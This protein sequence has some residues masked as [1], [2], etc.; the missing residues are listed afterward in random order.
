MVGRYWL[1]EAR[2]PAAPALAN[3]WACATAGA[4]AGASASSP[5]SLS[6]SGAGSSGVGGS[7][8]TDSLAPTS[9]PSAAPAT[10]SVSR[11]AS[12]WRRAVDSASSAS[13][14]AARVAAPP[15]TPGGRGTKAGTFVFHRPGG[16]G[17]GGRPRGA[18]RGL[19]P[20]AGAEK[21]KKTGQVR[22]DGH[23]PRGG[24]VA[25]RALRAGHTRTVG[26]RTCDHGLERQ[27]GPERGRVRP[28]SPARPGKPR[29]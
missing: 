10:L 17:P 25:H 16:F 14:T 6:A 27:A 9:R 12:C 26:Q 5:E 21:E 24:G 22:A 20:P 15:G 29:A 18:G 11:A 28:L 1:F 3:A 4:A 8:S 2:T 19:T 7:A 13:S 23:A